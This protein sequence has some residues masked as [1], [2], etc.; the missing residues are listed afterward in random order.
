MH[1]PP[2]W[3]SFGLI[4]ACAVVLP[5][6][7]HAQ[8]AGSRS[9][10]LGMVPSAPPAAPLQGTP[11]PVVGS[12]E[13]H[14]IYLSELGEASKTL[15]E[16]LRGLPFDTLYPVLLDRMIDHQAL[17][18]MAKQR[19]MEE[20]KPV[21]HDIQLAVERILEGAYLGD[22]AAP[23]VTEAA[24]QNRYNRQFANRPASEEV[25]ARHILVTTEAEARKVLDDLKMG[26]DFASIAQSVSKDPDGAKGGDLGFFRREQVWPNFADVAFSLQPGQI[27]PNP[28]KNEFGW[29]V[30]KIEEKRLVAP[31]GYS[32]VHE[33]LRQELLAASVQQ[34]IE[35]ARAGLAIHRFNLDGSELDTG[36]RLSTASPPP[37]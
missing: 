4:I 10:G 28:I 14:L 19:G 7:A 15:P 12:V 27:A 6:A 18:L 17:V 3:I 26:A 24:I 2:A 36:P 31:P 29:H 5:F 13:G 22:V 35:E 23:R 1:R 32:D 9:S 11:D 8:N 34:A 33:Q 37:R 30:V 25:R 16:N 20:R 21:Q